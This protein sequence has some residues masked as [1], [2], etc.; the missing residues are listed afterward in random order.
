MRALYDIC[1]GELHCKTQNSGTKQPIAA[2]SYATYSKKILAQKKYFFP[3]VAAAAAA[4]VATG[5]QRS[6]RTLFF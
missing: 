3:T 2:L 5:W 6:A 4:Y 1:K